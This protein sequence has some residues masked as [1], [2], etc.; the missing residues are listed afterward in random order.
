MT[1]VHVKPRVLMAPDAYAVRELLEQD[2]PV[3]CVLE[4]RLDGAPD[5]SP[6]EL[7]GFLW[8]AD[9]GSGG[10][11]RAAIFHG[12]NLLPVGEDLPALEAI[13]GQ[14][15]RTGR[16]CSSIV[17]TADAVSVIWPVLAR[18]WG[19]ARAVRNNQPFL[20]IDRPPDVAFDPAVR[21]VTPAET[22]RFLPAAAAMFTEE[23]GIPPTGYD[24]GAGYRARVTDL[25]MAGRALARFDSRGS[26][27]FKA[28]IGAVSAGGAQIQGVWVRP[29]LRGRGLGTPAMAA[30][31]RHALRL[32]PTATLYVNDYNE[33]ARRMYQ[34]LGMRQTHTL[35]TVLF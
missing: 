22:N 21:V 9:D 17:G 1:A 19:P 26:I 16:G 18:R 4:S 15:A 5:L 13:A 12:G 2:R 14:L 23:I 3:H 11:L 27:E 31:L 35:S 20:V 8:G 33:I 10:R 6:R 24:N 34:R 32:A 29:D 25:V 7:G 28:E 30:V